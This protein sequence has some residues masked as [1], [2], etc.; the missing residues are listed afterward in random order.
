MSAVHGCR[1]NNIEAWEKQ[2]QRYREEKDAVLHVCLP[3]PAKVAKLCDTQNGDS[4]S[5]FPRAPSPGPSLSS[6]EGPINVHQTG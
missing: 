3:S 2:W 4:I 1:A 5:S 6:V